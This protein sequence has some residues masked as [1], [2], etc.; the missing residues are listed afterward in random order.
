M[1]RRIALCLLGAAL[2]ACGSLPKAPELVG[3]RGL[4]DDLSEKKVYLPA[5]ADN[6]PEDAARYC[7]IR[8]N[9]TYNALVST[10]LFREV[11][12]GEDPVGTGNLVI[13]LHDFLRRPYYTTPA[14][15]PGFLLLSLAVPF[16]WSEQLGFRFSGQ[17]L[18][19][20]VPVLID[21]RWEG[22]AVMWSLASLLNIAP[23]R[24]FESTYNQDV[25]RLRQALAGNSLCRLTRR[26]S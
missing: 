14:H 8:L 23:S 11:T 9:D 13:D 6:L 3:S 4:S 26:C 25:A 20:G 1:T 17:E 16:W 7:R 12:I 24:T 10:K 2:L 18:P 21:T 15:N 19:K 22:T 5:C